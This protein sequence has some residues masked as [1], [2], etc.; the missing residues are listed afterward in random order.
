MDKI[1]VVYTHN[2]ILFSIKTERNSDTCYSKDK[3]GKHYVK[4]NKTSTKRT[5]I[6]FCLFVVPTIAKFIDTGSRRVVTRGWGERN[7]ELR[8]SEHRVSAC[9]DKNILQKWMVALHDVKT[10]N[11]TKLYT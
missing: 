4:L 5:N 7:G 6:Q 10:L 9:N 1:N 3:T 11:S 8:F 2:E